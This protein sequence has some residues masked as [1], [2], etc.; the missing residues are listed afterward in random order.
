[1]GIERSNNHSRNNVRRR[2]YIIE[3]SR[4]TT[5]KRQKHELEQTSKSL[6]PPTV[7]SPSSACI[8]AGIARLL[9]KSSTT[10]VHN[11]YED[12]GNVGGLGSRTS[13]RQVMKNHNLSLLVYGNTLINCGD[14]ITFTSP[15][16]RPT[17]P[18]EEVELN[19]YTSGRYLIMA[20]KHIAT[21]ETGTHEMILRCMKDSVRTPYPSE[22][23]PLIVGKDKT[24]IDNIYEQDVAAL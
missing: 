8:S 12:S 5:N 19:P 14:I 22:S 15:M 7:T 16:M 13:M 21:L 23:D 4:R 3:T 20:I 1:M 2:L 6:E 24:R 17:G 11:D 9:V 10:K 18:G